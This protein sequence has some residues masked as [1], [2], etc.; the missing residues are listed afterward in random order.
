LHAPW[1]DQASN[2][3]GRGAE[4][5]NFSLRCFFQPPV[6]CSVLGPSI[7]LSALFSSTLES[8]VPSVRDEVQQ[9][10]I[11]IYSYATCWLNRLKAS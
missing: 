1:F 8:T 2:I 10:N 5:W 6:T 4:T 3:F 11:F 7:L 9:R